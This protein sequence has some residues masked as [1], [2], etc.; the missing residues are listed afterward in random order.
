MLLREESEIITSAKSLTTREDLAL[1]I[2]SAVQ[3]VLNASALSPAQISM[4][5]LSTTLA[6]NALVEGQGE[7]IGLIYIGFRDGD[8]AKNNLSE[9]LKGD[10]VLELKGD[11]AIPVLKYVRW[12]KPRCA[13]GSWD[14]MSCL[15][16][17]WQAN[18][19]QEILRM[20]FVQQSS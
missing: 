11:T 12:M 10:P 18:S 16:S 2:E 13:L 15:P 9:A 5:S 17:Q 14:T 7:R 1:G 19:P 6:T 20:S 3:S 8:V 4:A